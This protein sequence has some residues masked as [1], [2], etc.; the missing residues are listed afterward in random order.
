MTRE[1]Q[2]NRNDIRRENALQ[3][4]V[5]KETDSLHQ[6]N[7]IIPTPEEV[8]KVALLRKVKETKLT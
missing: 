6:G 8:R 7:S 3:E 5:W 1:K 4:S 2:T